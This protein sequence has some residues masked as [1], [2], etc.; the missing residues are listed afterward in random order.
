MNCLSICKL[1]TKNGLPGNIIAPVGS[2]SN[3]GG[4]IASQDGEIAEKNCS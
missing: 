2:N 1:A 3:S 4:T